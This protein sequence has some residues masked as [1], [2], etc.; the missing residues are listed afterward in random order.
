MEDLLKL[1]I[2]LNHIL[3]NNVDNEDIDILNKFRMLQFKEANDVA[4]I[5]YPNEKDVKE[6]LRKI[7]E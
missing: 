5:I 1:K 2:A 7:E 6:Y 3:E 4:F